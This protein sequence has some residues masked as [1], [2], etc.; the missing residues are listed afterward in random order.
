M[1]IRF[2]KINV[3][4]GKLKALQEFSYEFTDGVYGLIGENGAGKTTLMNVMAGV[5]CPNFGDI[6]LNDNLIKTGDKE[7]LKKIGYLPQVNPMYPN[8]TVYEYMKYVS[9][10]KCIKSKNDKEINHLLELVNLEDKND[11]MCKNLSGGMKRRLGIAQ[12][13]LGNPQFLILDE[14]TAGVDVMERVKFRNI[15]SNLGKDR[16]ILFSTHMISDIERIAKQIIFLSNGKIVCSGEVNELIKRLEGSVWEAEVKQLDYE[17]IVNICG[18]KRVTN[19]NI[20]DFI[21]KV[22]YVYD[23]PIVEHAK[24]VFPSIEEVYADIMSMNDNNIKNGGSNVL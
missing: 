11:E 8:F 5:F 1:R 14:P 3:S 23:E 7:Y 17:K 24:L 21:F 9:Y 2:D 18:E 20:Q 13:L 6:F 19:V 12:A 22:R 15:I 16:I 10:L 4:Y